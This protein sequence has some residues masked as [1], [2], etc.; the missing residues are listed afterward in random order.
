MI[1]DDKQNHLLVTSICHRSA[2][3]ISGASLKNNSELWMEEGEEGEEGE[4]LSV[5]MAERW[6]E[7]GGEVKVQE[8]QGGPV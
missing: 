7:R 5:T 2:F 8:S 1:K 4:G 6:R 3:A